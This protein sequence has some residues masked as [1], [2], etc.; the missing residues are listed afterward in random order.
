[1]GPKQGPNK[2]VP[3]Q[4]KKKND[5]IRWKPSPGE[6]KGDAKGET[7][8]RRNQ[9]KTLKRKLR[10]KRQTRES[11]TQSDQG[12]LDSLVQLK[13]KC[14]QSGGERGPYKGRNAKF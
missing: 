2:H 9:I 6:R 7:P 11:S 3:M 14:E 1:M 10:A 12:N 13:T 4:Q 8:E 5:R